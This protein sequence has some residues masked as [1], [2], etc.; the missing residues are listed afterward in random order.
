MKEHDAPLHDIDYVP[1]YEDLTV[2]YPPG[3]TREVT[4]Q[5]G[6]H[7]VLKNLAD[8]YDPTSRATALMTLEEAR[9]EHKLVTGLLYV[10]TKTE[11]YED[12]LDLIEQPLASLPLERVRPP[13]Q[14]LDEILE[15]YRVGSV[16]PGSGGG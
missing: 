5:D 3:T 13:R 9:R 2:D 11:P 6:S 1:Y 12:E 16:D 14:V 8:D 7:I 4:M 10:D 15:S